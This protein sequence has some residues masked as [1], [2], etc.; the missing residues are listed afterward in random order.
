MAN[1][2]DVLFKS[3]VNN[4]IGEKL[5]QNTTPPAFSVTNDGN[6]N[7][8]VGKFNGD[9][10]LTLVST[11]Y[12]FTPTRGDAVTISSAGVTSIV[13]DF[14]TLNVDAATLNGMTITG[15]GIVNISAF[16][17]KRFGFCFKTAEQ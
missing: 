1:S 10:T 17:C 14:I 7:F 3:K 9:V 6:G 4:Y 8:T 12:V 16:E 2:K 5:S 13:V 11:D 15:A